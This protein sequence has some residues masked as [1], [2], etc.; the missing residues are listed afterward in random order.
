[1]KIKKYNIYIGLLLFLIVV[2]IFLSS[3]IA[4]FSQSGNGTYFCS[5]GSSCEEIQNSEYGSILGIKVSYF[6]F[7]SFLFLFIVLIFSIKF[8]K[9]EQFFLLVAFIGFLFSIYFIYIQFFIL[10]NICQNCMIID[11][12]MIIIFFIS[13]KFFYHLRNTSKLKKHEE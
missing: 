8:K 9:L 10:K 6:G 4:F 1:M 12:I 2:E 13:L 5:S 7:F 11:S 3:N